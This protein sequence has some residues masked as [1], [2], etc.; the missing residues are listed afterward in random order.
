MGFTTGFTGGV[1]VT[2]GI[3]YLTVLAHQRN[4]EQQAAILRQQTYVLSALT[5]PKA[6]TLPPTR[7]E[8]VAADR[9]NLTESIKD[10]WNAEVE[11][12]VRWAQNKDWDAVRENLEVAVGRL[13]VRAFGEVGDAVEK[14]ESKAAALAGDAKAKGPGGVASAAK[15]AYAEAKA[16]GSSALNVAEE[17]AEEAKGGL[18]SALSRGLSKGKETLGMAKAAVSGAENKAENKL[19]EALPATTAE[20]RAMKQ[21][22]E[23]PSEDPRS[24][25]EILAER[26]LPEEQKDH[27]NLKAL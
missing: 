27:A 11:S 1:T 2:L 6:P 24:P 17:K 12:T 4:R 14:G 3:A 22:Y 25:E 19:V 16:S 8:R 23:R 9:A 7:A 10:R 21:R 18:F 26:Y 13:W 15:N 5:D 20:E